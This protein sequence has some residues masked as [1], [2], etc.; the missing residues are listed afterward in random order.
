MQLEL[1]SAIIIISTILLVIIM[2]IVFDRHEAWLNYKRYCGIRES[3][4]KPYSKKLYKQFL[5]ERYG[6][7][8]R[9]KKPE[10]G[11]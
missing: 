9:N 10:G 1:I 4:N 2:L 3:Q 7:I 8:D 5:K 11:A 6:Y